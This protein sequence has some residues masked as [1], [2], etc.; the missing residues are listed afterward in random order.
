MFYL[1][2]GMTV[3]SEHS[4]AAFAA[5]L[6]E[7][8]EYT[9]SMGMRFV[10]IEPGIFTM[11]KDETP[12]PVEVAGA[13]WRV[14]GDFDEHPAHKVTI[15]KS[16]Y[17]GICEVT[18]EQYE[19]F[20]PEHRKLRGKRGFSEDDDEAVV[21]V[22]WHDAVRFC[23]WLS[24]KEGLP[25]RL[26]TE[27]EW[28][29]ACRA[30]T[31]TPF[32]TG[33]SLPEESLKNADELRQSDKIAPLHVGKAPPNDWGLYDMHGN[34]EEWCHDWYGPYGADNQVDP[35][36]RIDGDFK[37]TRG[38]SHTTEIYYLRSANRAGTIPEDRNWLIGFRVVLGELPKTK[39]L[40][41]P[42]AQES[43][44]CN[45]RQDIPSDIAEGPDPA[46]P[47]FI[48]PLKYVKIPPDSYG[49]MFSR[50]NHDPALAPCANGDVLAIWYTCV[51]E[52]GREL[53]LA[54]SRLRRGSQEWEPAAPFWDAPD[55]ND[56]APAMWFDGKDILYHFNGLSAGAGYKKGG[57]AL[58]MRTSKDNGVTWSKARFVNPERGT[59][60]EPI[61]S[62]P[63]ACEFQASEGHI[64]FVSDAP[65]SSSVLWIS[66]DEGKTWEMSEGKIAGIHAGVVQLKDGRLMAFG[67]GNDIDGR[68]PRSI[69]SDMGETWTYSPSPF[70]PLGG[71]QRLILMRLREGPLFFAS[72]TGSRKEEEYMPIKDSSGKE[73]MVTGLF[74]ALSFDEGET[75]PCIRLVSDDGPGREVETMDGRLFTMDKSHA[76][77]GGYMTGCQTED[78]LIHIISSIQHYAFNLEWL[79]TPPPAI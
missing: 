50:H 70:P 77:P 72:F 19:K 32:H 40:P 76:E 65:G 57:L 5:V 58:I 13:E 69:S 2:A 14:N 24:E 1:A 46:T 12:L 71:G 10:R 64:V 21:F 9:N 18:N 53:A 66:K 78:G 7:S 45:V 68:M 16:F 43:W 20:D 61:P 31:D 55:R 30:G 74:A 42:A 4:L 79:R 62:Q 26:P 41:I 17:M 36:G 28:E 75:W 15:S 56:H 6:P 59:P 52:P 33:N 23:E 11:G 8:K 73:R 29:Y 63:V 25:Y 49:P 3:L 35:V 47:Y 60:R 34:V 54:A 27:A 39:P 51:R 37:V 67:R 38:G 44:R 48:G 22:S